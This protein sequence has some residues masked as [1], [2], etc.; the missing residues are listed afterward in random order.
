MNDQLSMI[1]QLVNLGMRTSRNQMTLL[2]SDSFSLGDNCD[3]GFGPGHC[4]DSAHDVVISLNFPRCQVA[5][6][7]MLLGARSNRS[8]WMKAEGSRSW[9]QMSRSRA[10]VVSCVASSTP[11][12]LRLWICGHAPLKSMRGINT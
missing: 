2:S 12:C 1:I 4:I 9:Y 11:P 7:M 6:N 5:I 3:H 8:N 10:M